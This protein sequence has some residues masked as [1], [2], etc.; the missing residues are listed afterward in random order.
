MQAIN[1]KKNF[2]KLLVFKIFTIPGQVA[3]LNPRFIVTAAKRFLLAVPNKEDK[4]RLLLILSSAEIY[5]AAVEKVYFR[6]QNSA[7]I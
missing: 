4:Y 6:L 2:L 1:L 7:T 5:S 3:H